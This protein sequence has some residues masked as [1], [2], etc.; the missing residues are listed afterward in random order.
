MTTR[1]SNF[2]SLGA[3]EVESIAELKEKAEEEITKRNA[4]GLP[5]C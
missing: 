4:E 5:L 3:P 1:K 2:K